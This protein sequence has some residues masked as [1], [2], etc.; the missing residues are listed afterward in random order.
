MPAEPL[1]KKHVCNVYEVL[2]E[3]LF[4]SS[5]RG[6]HIE[7]LVTEVLAIKKKYASKETT[8]NVR[9]IA[10]KNAQRTQK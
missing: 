1:F 9:K 3:V 5:Q 8:W 2:T 7:L 4:Q 6:S 10:W